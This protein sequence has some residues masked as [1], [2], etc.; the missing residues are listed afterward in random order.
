MKWPL[1]LPKIL[2]KQVTVFT[3]TMWPAFAPGPLAI[4][5]LLQFFPGYAG[6]ARSGDNQLIVPVTTLYPNQTITRSHLRRVTASAYHGAA[7]KFVADY[8]AIVGKVARVTLLAGRPVAVSDV[9]SAYEFKQGARIPIIFRTPG[10]EI[11]AWGIALGAGAVGDYISV[12]N[13][14]S[15]TTVTGRITGGGAVSVS[16]R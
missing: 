7:E 2:G 14:K 15:G 4:L 16:R 12:R 5:L 8:K 1:L 9:R 3:R 11:V 6:P 10:I 13:I